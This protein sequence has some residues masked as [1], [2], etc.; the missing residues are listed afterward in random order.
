M[1]ITLFKQNIRSSIK[2]MLILFAVICLYTSVIIYMYNPELSEMLNGYQEALPEMMSA[3]GMT[4]LAS[5]ILEWI[6]IYLYGFIMNLFPMVFSIIMVNRVLMSY[7]DRGSIASI[8]SAPHSRVRIILTQ[9]VSAMLLM[10][11]LLA[12][13][14]AVGVFCCETMFPG[15]LDISG[16]LKLN[17]SAALL[18]L[19]ILSIAFLAACVCNESKYYYTFGAGI[20]IIEFL[21]LMLSNMGDKLETLKYLT[22]YSLF[23]ANEIVSGGDDYLPKLLAMTVITITLF[24]VGIVWF[25]RRDLSV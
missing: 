25:S 3:V 2:S 9:A 16:Y 1:I 7:I 20:P 13:V 21:L 5:N 8:L 10:L 6:Q 19:L 17:A 15:E 12:A 18:Q 4:G 14:T 24:A 11:L 22:V 23:P